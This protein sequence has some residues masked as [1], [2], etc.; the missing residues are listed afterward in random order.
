MRISDF[1]SIWRRVALVLHMIISLLNFQRLDPLV[2]VRCYF[3]SPN[4]TRNAYFSIISLRTCSY[5]LNFPPIEGGRGH[6]VL[7]KL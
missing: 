7:A 2:R 1:R 3:F 6:Y 4:F 5:L